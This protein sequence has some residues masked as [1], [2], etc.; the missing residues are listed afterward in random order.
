MTTKRQGGQVQKIHDTWQSAD[1]AEARATFCELVADGDTLAAFDLATSR[2][3]VWSKIVAER[4]SGGR[5]FDDD[6][7]RLRAWGDGACRR[8]ARELVDSEW[9]RIG[10]VVE[11]SND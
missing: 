9:E 7:K 1:L 2:L 11:V 6:G 8:A 3:K 5:R 10:G 4:E